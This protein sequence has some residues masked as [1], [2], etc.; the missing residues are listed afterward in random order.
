MESNQN[1]QVPSRKR[2]T[3][4]NLAGNQGLVL[5]NIVRNLVLIPIYLKYIEI[6]VFGAWLA[7]TGAVGFLALADLGLNDLLVQRTANLY[8]AKDFRHLGRALGSF[9]MAVVPLAFLIFLLFWGLAPWM[10]AWL[11]VKGGSSSDLV[12]AFRLG[13]LDAMFMLL[14][15]G[16]G[17]ILL[18]L[19]R[20]AIYMAGLV[21]AQLIGIVVILLALW[22]GWG[23]VAIPAGL[24]CGTSLAMV[25]NAV[26]LWTN[27]RR[28]L[29]SGTV[30]FDLP[31]LQELLRSS[32]MLLVV[33][34]CRL[35]TTRSYGMI[36]AVV[37]SAPLLVV[38]EVTYKAAVM[39]IDVLSRFSMSL[40]PGLSHLTGTGEK[41]KFQQIT[42]MLLHL[43]VVLS[44][45]GAGGVLLL[46]REFVSL[47][48]GAQYYGG[49][50][51][52]AL[53]CL[54]A[55]TQLVNS[56]FYN[57]IFA[58]GL[59]KAVTWASLCEASVQVSLAVI[60]G[61]FWGLKGVALAAVI[62]SAASLVIQVIAAFGL[63]A[64]GIF[65]AQAFV[66][67]LR[68]VLLGIAP[69]ALGWGV[70][71]YWTPRGWWQMGIFAGGYLLSGGIL[72]LLLDSQ[73]RLILKTL[74]PFHKLWA[75]SAM[76]K[77]ADI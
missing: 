23:V 33:R 45:L 46:N 32:S 51:L 62:A 77:S 31:T 65:A 42:L 55:V 36:I 29:P 12:L 57:I 76:P 70:I 22:A 17:A 10:P 34:I 41:E 3:W 50:G 73:L 47:W 74:L 64:R 4:I 7:F 5:L 63:L 44:L 38:F 67:A 75:R 8:A 43:T 56:A 40:L 2:S 16:T 9:L 1:N 68:M 30:K 39:I 72:M 15:F 24:L 6:E 49:D 14:V 27:L 61:Y 69:V 58:A 37:L 59:L 66:P 20:P 21:T 11:G 53:F 28:I 71:W 13:A 18:G 19:Q 26:S 48:T 60:L 35:F 54:Y 52:T 25:G